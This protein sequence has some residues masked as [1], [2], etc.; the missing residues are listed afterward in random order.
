LSSGLCDF[1]NFFKINSFFVTGL[2]LPPISLPASGEV[3]INLIILEGLSPA[4]MP[5]SRSREFLSLFE[6]PFGFKFTKFVLKI[7]MPEGYICTCF[8][9]S[10]EM[11]FLFSLNNGICDSTFPS[12]ERFLTCTKLILFAGYPEFFCTNLMVAFDWLIPL[13]LLGLCEISHSLVTGDLLD[14]LINLIFLI[15]G[16]TLLSIAL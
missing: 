15:D 6:L 5:F 1:Y 10:G 7:L 2:I 4:P 14:L 12:G 3:L 13:E 9:G 16:M 11:S 8:C